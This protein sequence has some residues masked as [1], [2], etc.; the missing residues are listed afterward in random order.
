MST[1]KN[2]GLREAARIVVLVAALFSCKVMGEESEDSLSLRMQHKQMR[3]EM[4]GE[5]RDDI[6][7]LLSLQS[8]LS[9]QIRELVGRMDTMEENFNSQIDAVK[10]MT[11]DRIDT[12]ERS[13]KTQVDAVKDMTEDRMD[14]MKRVS[15]FQQENTMNKIDMLLPQTLCENRAR[16]KGIF[17]QCDQFGWMVI[18][19]RVDNAYN[20]PKRK[21]IEYKNGFGDPHNSF[22]LGLAHIHG[23][24]NSGRT[25]LRVELTAFDGELRFAEYDSF[26]I[27][28]EEAG[29]R[30]HVSGYSG[31]AGDSMKYQNGMMFSTVDRDQDND[32]EKHCAVRYVGAWWY[33]SCFW[34]NLNSEYHPSGTCPEA[35]GMVWFSWLGMERTL[36]RV[37]MKLRF[38]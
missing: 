22:W 6:K 8:E 27:D 35:E 1:M 36:K 15:Q 37:T 12:L 23:I 5:M 16:E 38:D 3:G 30:L 25:R 10:D 17:A 28:G 21:W 24:T 26:R 9:G 32:A 34:S 7:T 13:I 29:F 33:N 19:R 2:S 11:E 18:Q 14:T 4:R 31:T 20:F